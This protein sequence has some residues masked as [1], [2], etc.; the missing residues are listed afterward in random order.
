MRERIS[1]GPCM[2]EDPRLFSLLRPGSSEPELWVSWVIAGRM[3]GYGGCPS[4]SYPLAQRTFLAPIGITSREQGHLDVEILSN[5]TVQ[6]MMPGFSRQCQNE[7]NMNY[8]STPDGEVWTEYLLE[9]HVLCK[10]NL[11]T[12]WC[13][14]TVVTTAGLGKGLRGTA[15]FVPIDIDGQSL[16]LGIGHSNYEAET[17]AGCGRQWLYTSFLYAFE[18]EAPFAMRAISKDF[19]YPYERKHDYW[20][21]ERGLCPRQYAHQMAMGL[22]WQGNSLVVSFGEQDCVG[23]VTRLPRS[24]ILKVLR[25]IPVNKT[26]VLSR[27]NIMEKDPETWKC[28]LISRTRWR[29]RVQPKRVPFRRRDQSDA[30]SA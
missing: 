3:S 25:T 10:L 22:Q 7:K 15:G 8:F 16:W 14:D 5:R 11:A 12:G 24:W 30:N 21:R 19:C 2:A 1:A 6:F 9:P 18:M 23:R 27:R 26:K 4:V 29:G 17:P 28:R 20:G 13:T